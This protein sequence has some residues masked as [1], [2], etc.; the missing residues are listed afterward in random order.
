MTSATAGKPTVAP[1]TTPEDRTLRTRGCP[2]HI[3]VGRTCARQPTKNNADLRP[4]SSFIA[5]ANPPAEPLGT[6]GGNFVTS[7]KIT[8]LNVHYH[9]F[10]KFVPGCREAIPIDRPAA[11]LV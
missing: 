7:G 3:C 4:T 1:L 11:Y 10:M 2:I 5:P 6:N 8:T 9:Y